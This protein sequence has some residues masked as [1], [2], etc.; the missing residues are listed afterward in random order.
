MSTLKENLDTKKGAILVALGTVASIGLGWVIFKNKDNI[1]NYIT[2]SLKKDKEEI[3]NDV[4]NI[5]NTTVS[6]ENSTKESTSTPVLLKK[7][8]TILDELVQ[9]NEKS[10]VEQFDKKDD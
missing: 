3:V 1:K 10:R 5:I 6:E 8:T 9:E 4:D 7:G 2:S